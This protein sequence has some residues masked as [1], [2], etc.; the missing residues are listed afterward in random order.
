MLGLA[1]GTSE[2]T[3]LGISEGTI[4]GV[5]VGASVGVLEGL[6]VGLG[7]IFPSSSIINPLKVGID[8]EVGLPVGLSVGD[9]EGGFVGLTDGSKGARVGVTEG[10]A[11]VG[12]FVGFA[13]GLTVS[14]APALSSS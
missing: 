9:P 4:V 12:S 14:T 1:D 3:K 10:A 13:V 2:C 11:V 7:I 5:N 8:E 6:A